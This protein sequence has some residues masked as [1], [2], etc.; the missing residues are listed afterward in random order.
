MVL[1]ILSQRNTCRTSARASPGPRW[2]PDFALRSTVERYPS[3]YR[4][5]FASSDFLHAVPP[6]ACL[7]VGFAMPC[8]MAE[9]RRFRVPRDRL[10]GQRR[11]GLDA[12]GSSVP[13]R[14]VSDLDPGHACK[15]K[16]ACLRP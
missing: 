2:A 5:A 10:R 1:P 8:T 6:W 9:W 7:A 16:E 4:R 13:S 3:D 12:G 14:Y 11:W 15:P